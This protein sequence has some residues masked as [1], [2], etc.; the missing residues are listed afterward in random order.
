MDFADIQTPALL[1]APD[2]VAANCARM[3]ARAH[4]LGVRL[5]PHMK[6]HKTLEIGR[7]QTAGQF[8]GIT[9][10]TLAEARFFADGGCDDITYAVPMVPGKAG[11][12]LDLLQRGLR[13]NL[14]VD[15]PDAAADLQALCAAQNLRAR[16]FLKIDCGYHR[17]GIPADDPRAVSLARDLERAPALDFAGLLTHAGHS[18]DCTDV[19]GVRAVAAQ[20]VGLTVGLARRLRDEGI[21]CPEVSIGSTPTCVHLEDATGVTE[22]RPGNYALFDCFQAAIGSC[23]EADIAGCVL[24][25][26]IGH[27]PERGALLLDA[28]ALALGKD[29]GATHVDPHCGFGRVVGFPHLRITGLSQ[30]HG[31]VTGLR[32]EDAAALPVGTRVRVLPN[33]I[34]LTAALYAAYHV[35]EGGRIT[36]QMTPA[37]GW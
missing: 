30:E 23:T 27:Y 19:A 2:I 9:V 31:K 28:G 18:Y 6:T 26:V 35:V 21:A 4:A 17:A 1:V 33:H 25:T 5:R 13:L 37:R 3:S 10:S 36:G 20:E 29:P 34:C 12:A 8:G 24:S 32:P 15:H 11:A 22:I 14:L 16:V 7:M